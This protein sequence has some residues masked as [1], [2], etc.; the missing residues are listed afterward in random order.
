MKARIGIMKEILGW[1]STMIFAVAIAIVIRSNVFAMVI[2]QQSSMENTLFEGQRLVENR[3]IYNFSEP[4]RGDIII[5]NKVTQKDGML[6]NI[7]DE[8]E[9][10]YKS[11][12][13]E[14]DKNTLV[15]RVIG[16]PGDEIDIRDGFLYLNGQ[17][18]DELY[19]K[20]STYKRNVT[21]PT[22]VPEGKVFV[23]GDNREH[24]SDSRD[25]GF[26]EDSQIEG[27]VLCRLWP[28]NKIGSI[29]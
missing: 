4:K 17:K 10:L 23:L 15:K 8:T 11:L 22:T 29:N 7:L 24:S 13:G 21:L 5:L 2:V 12:T 18:L 19:V 26:I 6:D 25:L 14:V 16:I 28:L 3:L 1:C 27:K 20:G 9:K